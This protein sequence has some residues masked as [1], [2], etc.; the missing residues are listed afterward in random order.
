[1]EKIGE[2]VGYYAKI[3]VAAIKLTDGPLSVGDTICI[4]GHNTDFQ[5]VVESMEIEHQSVKEAR[6]GDSVG[7]KVAERV[8]VKDLVYKV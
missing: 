7:T 1:M 2:V 5:Q 4:Q 6:V 8:R 3:G